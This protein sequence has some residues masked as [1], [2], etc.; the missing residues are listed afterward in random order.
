MS[1]NHLPKYAGGNDQLSV[2]G[3]GMGIT[4]VSATIQQL[5]DC[6]GHFH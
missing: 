2:I 4:P 6:F 1:R 3:V 5:G